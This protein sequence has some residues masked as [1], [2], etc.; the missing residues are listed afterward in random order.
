MTTRTMPAAALAA[1]VL[2]AGCYRAAPPGATFAPVSATTTDFRLASEPAGA[3]GVSEVRK[4]AGRDGD[5]VVVV[6][7][8]GGRA[9]PFVEGRAAFTI[10]D[11]A[12]K[13]CGE[14]EGCPTPW[15]YCCVANEDLAAAT[16]LVR[17][18]TA[19]GQ[20]VAQGARDLLGVKELQTVV[21]RG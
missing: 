18:V 1:V 12:L 7:R 8:I 17:F 14:D 16:V 6:G 4:A 15:D 10:V 20:P 5:E 3:K 19:D 21:V 13:P 9:K 11:P 2:A